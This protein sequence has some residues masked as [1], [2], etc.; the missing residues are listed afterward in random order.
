M[1]FKVD[2]FT[3]KTVFLEKKEKL[4]ISNSVDN[5]IKSFQ[6]CKISIKN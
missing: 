3:V 2:F 4:S 1:F 6:N 5:I